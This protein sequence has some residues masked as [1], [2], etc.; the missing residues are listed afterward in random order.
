MKKLALLVVV[1]AIVF[2][3]YYLQKDTVGVADTPIVD[4]V[5]GVTETQQYV[6]TR[7]PVKNGFPLSPELTGITG[8]INADE[9]I[10]IRDFQGKVVLVD[11]WTYS[12]INC[13]RTLPYL[14][15]WDAK[16]KDKGLV[17]IG[18]HA[19]EFEF[20][21]DTD[22]VRMAMGKYGI[23]YRVVQDNNKQTW[24]AFQN[25]FWPRKYLIDSEGYI[26]YDHIGEGGYEETERK[27]QEL[28]AE[29]TDMPEEDITV[30]EEQVA[31][32]TT[33]ELYLGYEFAL[34]R[35]QDVGDPG[36]KPG[37]AVEYSFPST[38]KR[39]V[40]YLD[41]RWQSNADNVE[42]LGDGSLGLGFMARSVNIVADAD[43]PVEVD[44]L[45]DDHYVTQEAGSD[46]I[47]DGERSYIVVDEARL[48]NVVDG[49]YQQAGL[50][51]KMH[52]DVRV[53]SFTFG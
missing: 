29:I 51:L 1:V 11:F 31:V 36:L 50:E 16:Y 15:A 19:P 35:G 37:E 6:E 25:R 42:S 52:G 26:R 18:V 10:H 17:I 5:D 12:C 8:Y 13:I 33:P 46:V 34:P 28:L 53:H 23:E 2:S 40:I 39:D 48:Y 32:A 4:E 45:V 27:I 14:T 9:G 41:G 38:L 24:R 3:I 7:A 22:N 47:F 43:D 49:E 44:V 20:E 21:K 30:L